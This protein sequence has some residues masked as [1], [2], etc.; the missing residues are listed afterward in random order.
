MRIEPVKIINSHN[1]VRK[2]Q[3]QIFPVHFLSVR[4]KFLNNSVVASFIN[5]VRKW[6]KVGVNVRLFKIGD[7]IKTRLKLLGLSDILKFE[8]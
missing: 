8:K 6:M 4:N 2:K 5:Q 3:Y 1:T 7:G